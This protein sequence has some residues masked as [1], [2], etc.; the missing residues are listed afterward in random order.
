MA[1]TVV[2][3]GAY[4][5]AQLFQTQ[6]GSLVA[7]VFLF[8]TETHLSSKIGLKDGP[9]NTAGGRAHKALHFP[10]VREFIFYPPPPYIHTHTQTA[11]LYQWGLTLLSPEYKVGETQGCEWSASA[12][13]GATSQINPDTL[14]SS[15]WALF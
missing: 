5:S 1:P 2:S 15:R 8:F 4:W 11:T 14:E 12:W 7:S 3:A 9:V 6:A 13:S 10:Q